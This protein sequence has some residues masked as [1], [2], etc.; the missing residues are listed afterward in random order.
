MTYKLKGDEQYWV[1][2]TWNEEMETLRRDITDIA[3][4]KV[5]YFWI[6]STERYKVLKVSDFIQGETVI[7]DLNEG[8]IESFEEAEEEYEYA[9]IQEDRPPY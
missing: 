2:T 5:G 1:E 3:D 4:D 7:T 9:E 8:R 6:T